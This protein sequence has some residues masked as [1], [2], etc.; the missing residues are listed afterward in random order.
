MTKQA[1]TH[2][3]ATD[4][5]RVYIPVVLFLLL[6]LPVIVAANVFVLIRLGFNMFTL[7]G[8][9]IVTPTIF[10]VWGRAFM[11]VN[12]MIE[13]RQRKYEYL[14]CADDYVE[15]PQP[16]QTKMRKIFESAESLRDNRA[17]RDGMFGDLDIDRVLYSASEQA[18][19]AATLNV[20]KRKLQSV[21]GSVDED[22]LRRAR[23]GLHKIGRQLDQV[24]AELSRAATAANSL[25]TKII[26]AEKACEQAAKD[27]EA[28][29]RRDQKRADAHRLLD[30]A[31]MQ[32]RSTSRID[33]GGIGDHVE[34]VAAGYDD[35]TK[36]TDKVL[37]PGS[38]EPAK[39]PPSFLE[40]AWRPFRAAIN[41]ATKP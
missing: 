23:A 18:V 17:H 19:N 12:D 20:A 7:A 29:V 27:S 32:T 24:E 28:T 6:L 38:T 41:W 11:K 9:V 1:A 36:I 25:S 5:S 26:A 13:S 22:G 33:T 3:T 15:A 10:G 14:I 37:D 4:P 35:A 2:P 16:I 31:V 39:Q 30:N 8:L 34:S 21:P 40:S